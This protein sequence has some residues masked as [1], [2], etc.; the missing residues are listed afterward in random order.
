M[1]DDVLAQHVDELL[2]AKGIVNATPQ[3]KAEVTAKMKEYIQGA[4]QRHQPFGPMESGKIE[5]WA[6]MEF[7]KQFLSLN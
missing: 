6:V 2:A 1:L 3:M 4:L 7:K 5:G